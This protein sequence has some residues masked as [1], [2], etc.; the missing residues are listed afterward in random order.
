MLPT[1]DQNKGHLGLC[2]EQ[3][4]QHLSGPSVIDVPEARVAQHYPEDQV[5]LSLQDYH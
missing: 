1:Q 2:E 5:L 3:V 4:T